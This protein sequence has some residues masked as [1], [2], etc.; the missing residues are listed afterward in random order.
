MASKSPPL[1]SLWMA[2]AKVSVMLPVASVS[3][4]P[5]AGLNVGDGAVSCTGSDTAMSKLSLTVP[6]LPSLAVTFTVTVPASVVS[7]VPEKV[8][9]PASKLSQSGSALPSDLVAV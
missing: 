8:R 2:S 7:G 1:A 6:P 4:A 3:V 9:V 5:D